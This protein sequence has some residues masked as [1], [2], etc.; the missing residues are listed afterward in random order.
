MQL[1]VGFSGQS[2]HASKSEGK[3]LITTVLIPLGSVLVAVLGLLVQNVPWWVTAVVIFY[4][5]VV[6]LVGLIPASFRVYRALRT[7][8]QRRAVTRRYFLSVRRFLTVLSPS[9]EESRV[10]TVFNVWK[11]AVSLDQ[12]RGQVRPDYAHLR[13]LQSW[14]RSIDIR[15]DNSGKRS[16]EEICDEL[17]DV[18]LQFNRLCEQAHREIET[19]TINGQLA[20]HSLRTLKQDWSNARD[21]HNQ[22]AKAWEDLAKNIN[23]DA[24]ERVCYDHCDLLKTIG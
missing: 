15:L 11:G 4:V 18:V 5:V 2:E 6:A 12:A 23:H 22:T 16:F 13:T 8:L 17:G 9:L 7:R 21:K 24:G 14:L 10:D 19:L 20:E 1:P 3:S